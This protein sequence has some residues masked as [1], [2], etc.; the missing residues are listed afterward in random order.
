MSQQMADTQGIRLSTGPD[1]LT[2]VD[3]ALETSMSHQSNSESSVYVYGLPV[4]LWH[5]SM[6]AALTVLVIT[7]Y[8]IGMPWHSITGDPTKLFYMGFTRMAHFIA[9]YVLIIGFL[10]RTLYAFFGTRYAREIY[11]LPLLTRGW[12]QELWNDIK[13]YLFIDMEPRIHLGHNPLA[14]VGMFAFML[15][16]CLMMVTGIGMYAEEMYLWPANPFRLILDIAYYTGGNSID[17]HSWHR[18]GMKLVIAFV[19]VHLYMVTREEIMGKTTLLSTMLSGFREIYP[20]RR[21]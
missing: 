19:V 1:V 8:I 21:G 20:G 3:S 15:F 18:L 14:R 11:Y 7:G 6:A 17:L 10:G 2:A 16:L 12:W 4:R 9:G 13:W 5:W